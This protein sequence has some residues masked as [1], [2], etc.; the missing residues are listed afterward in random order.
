MDILRIEANADVRVNRAVIRGLNEPLEA[1]EID[2]GVVVDAL[3]G[4]GGDGAAQM[5]LLRRDDIHVLRTDNDVD[6]LIGRKA[7]V[8]ALELAAEELDDIVLQHHAVENIG[9]ADEIRDECVLRLVIDILRPADLLEPEWHKTR[10]E[11]GDQFEDDETMLS[12]ILF[13]QITEAFLKRK[14]IS[15]HSPEELEEE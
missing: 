5:A 11:M 6:R 3:E 7:L 14:G 9:L 4:N 12:Y 1:L 13:P 10:R 8:H 2:N 15:L